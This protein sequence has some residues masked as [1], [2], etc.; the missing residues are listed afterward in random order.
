FSL[1]YHPHLLLP[2]FPVSRATARRSSLLLVPFHRGSPADSP[3]RHV[4]PRP[5]PEIG[6]RAVISAGCRRLHALHHGL[7]LTYQGGGKFSSDLLAAFCADHDIRQTFTLPASPQQ[8]GVAE[9]RI[10][11]VMEVAR[12]SMIH[13]AA[14]HFI[15]PFLVQYAARQLNLWPRIS[16]PETSPTLRSTGEVGDAL[17]FRVWGCRAFVRDT[18]A[19]KL[20][21][22]A[23]PCVFLGFVPDAHGWQCPVGRPPSLPRVL[24]PSGVSQV[25]SVEPIEVAV[26]SG[27]ARGTE[28]TEPGGAGS[29]GTETGVA[30]PRGAETGGAEP[31]GAETKGARPG[32]GGAPSSQQLREWYSQRYS[33]RRGA[34]GA[35][36]SAG[37]WAS[38]LAG[39]VPQPKPPS[40]RRLREWYAR[41]CSLRSGAPSV[42]E[43]SAGGPTPGGAA[44]PTRGHGGAAGAAGGSGAAGGA[45]GAGGGS[46]AVGGAAGAGSA[47]GFGAVSAGSGGASQPRPYFPP[48]LQQV[49][50]GLTERREPESRPVSPVSRPVSPIRAARTGRRESSLPVLADPESHSLRAASPTVTRL[51]ATIVTD[52][53]FESP[54]ASSL[55][56]ELVDFAAHCRLDYA[57]SLV[58][59]SESVCPP[60]VGGECALCTDVLEDRQEEL[61]CHAV[62]APHLVSMLIAPKG[63]PDAPDIPNPRSYAEAIAGVNIVSGMWIFRVKQPPG[64]PPVFKARYVDRGFSQQEGVDF[65]Q[66]F[67]PTPKMSTLRVLLHVAAQRDYELHSLDFSL[68]FLQGS[69][70]EEI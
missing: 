3:P 40:P 48:L 5:R 68:A 26:D 51:L 8:N 38:G 44:G 28:C 1:P 35:G 59:E 17:V 66:T 62:A 34:A 56:A 45:A 21:S 25:D 47:R 24:L 50:G 2:V 9:R 54:A 36:G 20:S 4:G 49:L 23:V 42:E 18:S 57:A 46:R 16:V 69:L 37:V 64:S 67:S 53:S 30:E 6:P 12:T 32:P 10:G 70:H 13:A 15:W 52:P 60:S 63:D 29:G 39:V 43:P 65:F 11:L 19:D 31:G 7:P 55:V 33:L 22:R 27:P 14:P 61:E 58:A 41:R